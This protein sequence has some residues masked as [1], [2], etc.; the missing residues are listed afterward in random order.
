MKS[1][2]ALHKRLEIGYDIFIFPE[3][4]HT[5]CVSYVLDLLCMA[6]AREA[7][8]TGISKQLMISTDFHFFISATQVQYFTSQRQ[9]YGSS[10][11]TLNVNF[12]YII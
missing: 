3:A 7:H 2:I 11:V 4:M 9:H 1:S 5:Q 6:A 8:M 10:S 12:E